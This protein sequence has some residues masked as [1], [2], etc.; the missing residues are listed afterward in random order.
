MALD[1]FAHGAGG[2]IIPERRLRRA[3]IWYWE[4][5]FGGYS[6]SA[7]WTAG[8]NDLRVSSNFDDSMIV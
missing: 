7:G 4:M 3:R 1:Q 2:V 5:W 8:F 6:G